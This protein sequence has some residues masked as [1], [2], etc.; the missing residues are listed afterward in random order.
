METLFG[1][2]DLAARRQPGES[3][4]LAVPSDRERLIS[5]LLELNSSASAEFLSQFSTEQL[6][7]YLEHLLSS[8]GPRGSESAW[9]RPGDTRAVLAAQS[10]A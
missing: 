7:L 3:P 2:D 4:K 6:S 1:F 9:Q 5:R 8:Q 10:A